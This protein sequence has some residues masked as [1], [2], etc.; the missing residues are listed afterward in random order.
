MPN[1]NATSKSRVEHNSGSKNLLF[2][3]GSYVS[4]A[5]PLIKVWKEVEGDFIDEEAVDG[6]KIKVEKIETTRDQSGQKIVGYLVKLTVEGHSVR[7]HFYDTKVSM[8]VQAAA[9]VLESYCTRALLPYLE[10]QIRSNARASRDFNAKARAF[11]ETKATTRNQHKQLL[12]KPPALVTPIS[13]PE[14]RTQIFR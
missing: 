5:V 10:D 3:T 6:M 11:N 14:S 7:I 8:L 4:T 2:S 9:P 1:I 12:S 13:S